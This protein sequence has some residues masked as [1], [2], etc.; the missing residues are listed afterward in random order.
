MSVS[1]LKTFVIAALLLLCAM[2]LTLLI[3]N[4]IAHNR[5]RARIQDALVN[6][7]QRSGV[8]VECALPVDD[9]AAV[10]VT[11][12]DPFRESRLAVAAIGNCEQT[13]SAAGGIS[14]FE[15]DTGS[16]EFDTLGGFTVEYSQGAD[17]KTPLSAARALLRSMKIDTGELSSVSEGGF[18]TVTAHVRFKK[19]EIVNARVTFEFADGLLR[20]V[21]GR[22]VTRAEKSA[23]DTKFYDLQTLMVSLLGSISR[24]D[25]R[26]TSI[27]AVNGA[28][29]MGVTAFG[30]G[31]LVPGWRVVTDAGEWF[32][33]AETG[34]CEVVV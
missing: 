17:G 1:R 29:L 33:N 13:E 27:T 8:T 23:A 30:D 15:N 18:T 3:S 12:R 9:G 32:L 24:G 26:C 6:T 11:V 21:T 34:Q 31:T 14:R 4:A 22:N 16:I 25:I 19:S 10:F 7:Y 28:Y 5:E 20:R 2:F